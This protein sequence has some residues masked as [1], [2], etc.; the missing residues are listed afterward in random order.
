MILHRR[1][2]QVVDLP[3]KRRRLHPVTLSEAE[4]TGFDHRV[5]LVLD[6]YRRRARLGEVRRDA[7]HLAL[8]TSMRQIAAEFK[9]PAAQ[10]LVE[11]LRRQGE[12]VVL[13]SGFV[14]PL[15]LL[16]QTLGGE[17]LT[18][19]QRPAERQESVDRFQQGQNDCLLAT[20]GTG[21]LG[22]TLHRARHVV[23]L[24]RPWTPGDLDQAEDRCHRLGMGDGLTCHWL[25]LGAADQLVDGLLA[26]KAERI[27]VL[28]GPR[29]LSLQRQSL[30]A[31]VRDCL[32]LL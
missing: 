11:S 23:L 24:E 6:D 10:Q 15:H 12:A 13:F 31:M 19:R 16:Q 25:Q 7:E 30:P 9:L 1:K 28:L 27:E 22:F 32:Q 8:L 26:S 18:G 17:L 4:L 5:E 21:A 20:F 29:R 14:A 3:P 2:Q